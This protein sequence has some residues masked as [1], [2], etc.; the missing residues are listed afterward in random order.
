M[1]GLSIGATGAPMQVCSVDF[2]GFDRGFDNQHELMSQTPQ[3][4]KQVIAVV[5]GEQ[6]YTWVRS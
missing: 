1:R 3:A 4:V 6:L 2:L 5:A